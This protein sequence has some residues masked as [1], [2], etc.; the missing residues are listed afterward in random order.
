MDNIGNLYPNPCSNNLFIPISSKE[1]RIAQIELFTL[2][3]R[4]ITSK[5]SQMVV[6]NSTL[7][8][9]DILP[10]LTSGVY[11]LVIDKKTIRKF[12]KQ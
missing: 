6:G 5:S 9:S 3:G 7:N 11:L 8:L 10:T 4:L 12:V 2:D 1:N